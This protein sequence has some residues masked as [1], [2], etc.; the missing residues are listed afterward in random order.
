MTSPENDDETVHF[1][2]GMNYFGYPKEYV[3]CFVHIKVIPTCFFTL[4][5]V[6][7]NAN[8]QKMPP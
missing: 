2:N 1:L 4:W 5:R 6:K 3:K 8:I 7:P